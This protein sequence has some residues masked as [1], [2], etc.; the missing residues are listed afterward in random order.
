MK[1]LCLV[2]YENNPGL[3]IFYILN[4]F[5]PVLHCPIFNPILRIRSFLTLFYTSR[6]RALGVLSLLPSLRTIL[7][8]QNRIAD[9]GHNTFAN[10]VTHP[11]LNISSFFRRQGRHSVIFNSSISPPGVSAARGFEG[12]SAVRPEPSQPSHLRDSDQW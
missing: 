3:R 4:L 2:F 12:Q 10:K 6:I 7:L 5:S 9:I 1:Y 11:L 8:G